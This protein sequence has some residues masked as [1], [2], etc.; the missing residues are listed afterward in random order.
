M[1]GQ[2]FSVMPGMWA[3]VRLDATDAVPRWALDTTDFVS[4]TRTSDELSI[5][6]P[7]TAAPHDVR[8]ERGWGILKLHGPFPFALVG[9][10]ASFAT[11]LAAAGVS[12]FGISTFDTDYVLVKTAQLSAAC[13]ALI[14]A[15]HELIA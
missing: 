9:V 8:S 11:P 4:I 15:G 13:Q 14:A 5:V 2:R 12:I 3:V 7:E 10:M 6:C 1:S